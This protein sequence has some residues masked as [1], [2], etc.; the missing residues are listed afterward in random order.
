MGTPRVIRLGEDAEHTFDVKFDGLAIDYEGRLKTF[1]PR[2]FETQTTKTIG[3]TTDHQIRAA[4][5]RNNLTAGEGKLIEIPSLYPIAVF[6]ILPL[7]WVVSS[8]GGRKKAK[9]T[10]DATAP[11]A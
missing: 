5:P 3:I 9:A 1:G 11:A 2:G 7:L 4:D 6:G 8:L 10:E